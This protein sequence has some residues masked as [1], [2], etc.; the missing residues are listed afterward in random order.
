MIVSIMREWALFRT[1][2]ND[3]YDIVHQFTNMIGESIERNGQIDFLSSGLIEKDNYNHWNCPIKLSSSSDEAAPIIVNGSWIGGGHGQPCGVTV[4]APLHG[5]TNKDVGAVYVDEAG[6][7]FT[8]LRIFN[9]DYITFVSENIGESVTAYKFKTK[10]DGKL[11][12]L[13]DGEDKSDV[14]IIESHLTLLPQAVK[15][16]QRKLVAYKD[17]KAKTIFSSIECDYAEIWESYDIIN[18][19]T[20]AP[21]LTASRPQGGY[22][23]TPNLSDYG[24]FMISLDQKF[25]IN[26]DGTILVD[27][28]LEK[29][30][31][32]RFDTCLGVMY[33]EKADVF[34]GGKYRF[35]SKTKPFTTPEGTFD[36][37]SPYPL[38]GE[39]Y[40]NAYSPN[41]NDFVD[42][43]NPFDRIVDYFRDVNGKDRLGFTCGYLPVFDGVPEKRKDM[44][45]GGIFIYKTRKAYPYFMSNGKCPKFRGVGFK[46]FFDTEQR[47]SVYAVDYDKKKYIYFDIF[48]NNTLEF[49]TNGNVTLLEASGIDYKIE[50]GKIIVS[51]NKGFAT[52]V[53]EI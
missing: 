16:R 15:H 32:V 10:A 40:P 31:D 3:K 43:D 21:A 14:N 49:N 42:P 27:F 25:I 20:I 39:A 23:Y 45:D 19:A 18:P 44:I 28:A 17:G 50:R 26:P 8:I 1:H 37:S 6:I 34:G 52:F 38:R 53:E 4:Y 41:K 46:K 35:L 5:K 9:E 12:F 36:F 22:T 11:T 51:G 48:E 47:S 13:S 7:K 24:E 30:M 2:F 29:L 33:Q